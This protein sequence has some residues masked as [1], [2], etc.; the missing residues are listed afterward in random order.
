MVS[1]LIIG[2]ITAVVVTISILLQYFF[3]LFKILF[4][5]PLP[6]KGAVEIDPVEHVYAHPDYTKVLQDPS[7]L[8]VQTVYEILL[9]GLKVSPD[10]PQFAFRYSSDQPF[11]NYTYK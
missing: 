3:S 5:R 4:T 9:K 2:I 8:D 10:R 7:Q 11:Q 6:P 1:P